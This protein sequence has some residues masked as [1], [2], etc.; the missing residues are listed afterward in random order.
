M[1]LELVLAG[2]AGQDDDEGEAAV[3]DDRVLDG[4]G[5]LDLIRIEMAAAGVR[6]GD[7]GAA[8]GFTEGLGEEGRKKVSWVGF[9]KE[10]FCS[11]VV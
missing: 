10:K 5:D 7:G 11:F 3:I 9:R 8:D 2:L 1:G 6:P 4:E